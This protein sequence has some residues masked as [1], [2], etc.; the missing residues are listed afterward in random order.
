ME[1]RPDPIGADLNRR[2][3]LLLQRFELGAQG[4]NGTALVSRLSR[5]KSSF[6]AN[7]VARGI[8]EEYFR[9]ESYCPGLGRVRRGLPK[10]SP[11]VRSSQHDGLR[12]TGW[13]ASMRTS[14]STS[15]QSCLE[16]QGVED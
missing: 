7:R 16:P 5:L 2:H 6:E 3:M 12:G 8:S 1:S 10:A 14:S 15:R 9:G 11:W 13:R 4:S